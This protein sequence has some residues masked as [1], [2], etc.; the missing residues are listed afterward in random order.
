MCGMA[1][2][3]IFP[4]KILWSKVHDSHSKILTENNIPDKGVIGSDTAEIAVLVEILPPDYDYRLPV[5][6][7]VFFKDENTKGKEWYNKIEVEKACRALL[8]QWEKY[9]VV[10]SGKHSFN[11]EFTKIILGGEVEIIGQTG[12][13]CK[14]YENSTGTVSNQS[15]G[16]CLF[17]ENSTGTVS[18]QSGGFCRFNNN[19]TGTVS[20]Q[21]GGDCRFNNNSTGIVSNQSGGD[22]RFSKD[23]VKRIS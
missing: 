1:S 3:V 14:F 12:G 23:K 6:R 9:H 21:S 7:W 18:N 5:S 16:D 2:F 20:N 11:G 22:C 8:P 17:F 10:K 13:N 15:D 4:D 19:S